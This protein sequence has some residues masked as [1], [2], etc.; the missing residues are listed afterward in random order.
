MLNQKNDRITFMKVHRLELLR[1]SL[2]FLVISCGSV[3]ISGCKEHSTDNSNTQN[4]SEGRTNTNTSAESKDK[5]LNPT[6]NDQRATPRAYRSSDTGVGQSP[7]TRAD[8]MTEA[9]RNMLNGIQQLVS[10]D[11]SL[12]MSAKSI[13][14]AVKNGR[15]SLFGTVNSPEERDRIIEHAQRVA[16][17]ANV[18]DHLEVISSK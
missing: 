11:N 15:A 3:F 18:D 4:N 5:S 9:D 6:S 12:S 13:Q 14:V 7:E 17:P 16:G 8:Q 2:A 10:N 1:L